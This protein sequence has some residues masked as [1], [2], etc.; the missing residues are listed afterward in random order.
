MEYRLK[1]QLTIGTIFSIFMVVIFIFIFLSQ[2]SNPTCFD[3]ILNQNEENIDCGGS[4]SPCIDTYF[5]DIEVLS[6]DILLF[7]GGYDVFARIKNPNSRYGIGDLKYKF[8]FYDQDGNFISEKKGKSYILASET[9]YILESNLSVTPTPSF[10]RFEVES[11]DWQEQERSIVKLPIFSK[12][13][14]SVSIPGSV[15]V[16][17]VT[18]VIENQTNYSFID[19]DVVVILFDDNEKQI[20]INQTKINNLR[21]A[22]RRGLVIPWFSKIDGK[23][24]KVFM[25]ASANVFDDS[26][27]LR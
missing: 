5:E 11:I 2:K 14:E 1:R 21:A 22:E 25:E 16:S 18:G 12:K 8:K 10:V 19:V 9:K 4:C 15:V 23:V 20:A 7:D 26:N 6:S 3:E 13:Y 17:Q 24:S 27:I